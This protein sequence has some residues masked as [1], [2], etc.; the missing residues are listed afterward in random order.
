MKG[1]FSVLS[2]DDMKKRA[3]YEREKYHS[4]DDE[5]GGGGQRQSKYLISA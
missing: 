2:M 1:D 3:K 4:F 5:I